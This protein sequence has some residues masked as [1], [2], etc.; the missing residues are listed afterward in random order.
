M[1]GKQGARFTQAEILAMPTIRTHQENG[2]RLKY[3]NTRA[4]IWVRSDDRDVPQAIVFETW[5]QR[6]WGVVRTE[7]VE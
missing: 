4:R 3:E 6:R 1:P 2:D 7:A 5:R